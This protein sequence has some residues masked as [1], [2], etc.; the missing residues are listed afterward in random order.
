[1]YLQGCLV[2]GEEGTG[3]WTPVKLGVSN[4]HI[5]VPIWMIPEPVQHVRLLASRDIPP[6]TKGWVEYKEGWFKIKRSEA[7]AKSTL[8]GMQIHYGDQHMEPFSTDDWRLIERFAQ[9]GILKQEVWSSR[10]QW[11]GVK[12]KIKIPLSGTEFNVRQ[13]TLRIENLPE[14]WP[15][16]TESAWRERYCKEDF[17]FQDE[18]IALLM[19]FLRGMKIQKLSAGW[20]YLMNSGPKGT[21]I[22]PTYGKEIQFLSCHPN[23]GTKSHSNSWRISSALHEAKVNFECHLAPSWNYC[24]KMVIWALPLRNSGSSMNG[25]T[26]PLN[27]GNKSRGSCLNFVKHLAAPT[28]TKFWIYLSHNAMES[29]SNMLTIRNSWYII[30][31]QQRFSLT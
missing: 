15:M 9:E 31:L 29:Y 3:L 25:V 22:M 13:N 18:K 17:I 11:L 5:F 14:S 21:L 10:L 28:V 27:W 24:I 23:L 4:V 19:T 1:M 12:A 2:Q 8:C 16:D 7:T 26:R 30:Q 20:Q 6:K